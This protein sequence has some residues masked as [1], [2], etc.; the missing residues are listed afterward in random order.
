MG[1]RTYILTGKSNCYGTE[2]GRYGHSTKCHRMSIHGVNDTLVI[3]KLSMY[4]YENVL[5]RAP[6][7]TTLRYS[8]IT[9]FGG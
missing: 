5:L 3:N 9:I 4:S 1:S 8:L 6:N 2:F 7:K